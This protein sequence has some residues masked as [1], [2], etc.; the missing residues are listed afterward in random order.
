M[1]QSAG[2]C[3]GRISKSKSLYYVNITTIPFTDHWLQWPSL[4]D[5]KTKESITSRLSPCLFTTVTSEIFYLTNGPAPSRLR[6]EL[7]E[8]NAQRSR[9]RLDKGT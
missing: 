3:N 1:I 5:L 6:N 9:I 4:E 8:P 2:I 7:R